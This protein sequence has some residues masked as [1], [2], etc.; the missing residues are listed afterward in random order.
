MARPRKNAD[1]SAPSQ[2]TQPAAPARTSVSMSADL[3]RQLKIIA[4]EESDRTK[5]RV[6]VAD[7]VEQAVRQVWFADRNVGQV[8]S[9]SSL[10][11]QRQTMLADLTAS[12]EEQFAALF[13]AALAEPIPDVICQLEGTVQGT[14]AAIQ[15]RDLAYHLRSAI[16]AGR[17]ICSLEELI[18]DYEG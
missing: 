3:H 2:S 15:R 8:Q 18:V 7:L 5:Q 4:A 12:S 1:P 6:S 17:G 16:Q 10:E 11:D 13:E 9:G 14:F